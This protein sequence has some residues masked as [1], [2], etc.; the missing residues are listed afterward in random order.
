MCYCFSSVYAQEISINDPSYPPID[1]ST[2]SPVIVEHFFVRIEVEPE[3]PDG[4]Q[5]LKRY[6]LSKFQHPKLV[7]RFIKEKKITVEFRVD[8]DCKIRILVVEG[9]LKKRIK[10]DLIKVFTKLPRFKSVYS[11]GE[12]RYYW[13]YLD[14]NFN[15]IVNKSKSK[16]YS[17]E[18]EGIYTVIR[19]K[20]TD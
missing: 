2:I 3:F 17:L 20:T 19:L 11:S 1:S 16:I 7:A 5:A 18:N 6:L 14:N 15:A 8:P 12:S 13:F 10:N 4:N 9:K